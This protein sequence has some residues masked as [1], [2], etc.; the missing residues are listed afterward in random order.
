[1]TNENGTQTTELQEVQV[2]F[3][4]P[5]GFRLMTDEEAELMASQIVE[6]RQEQW[7][8][9]EIVDSAVVAGEMNA[10]MRSEL[11]YEYTQGGKT[12]RGLTAKMIGHLATAQGISEVI[13][14][15]KSSGDAE[16]ADKYEFEVVVEMP[17]PHNPQRMLYRTGYAEE[18]KIAY[19][20][21]DKFARAKTH[22]KAY[23]NA[24]LKFLPQDLI[25]ATTFKLANLVPADW[26]PKPQP[27]AL[28]PAPQNGTQTDA[29]LRAEKA[30]FATYNDR[31]EQLDA[32]GITK[33]IFWEGVKTHF[34]VKSRT[35]MTAAQYQELREA[36]NVKGFAN[37][38][39]DL[40]PKPA[41]E[42][43]TET[44]TEADQ[45]F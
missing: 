21:Y 22:T 17:D 19:G 8:I 39:Q 24:C 5:E 2:P 11:Y 15:R 26:T 35:D 10:L 41:T 33:E 3:E 29:Q 4:V 16:D 18:P 1:M 32:L 40:A 13:E 23:R 7:E 44:A 6:S 38:I 43:A 20:K 12:V 45:P 34:K 9:Q 36:L 25:M 42:T 28:P 27:K 30:A 14:L 31:A 37:W